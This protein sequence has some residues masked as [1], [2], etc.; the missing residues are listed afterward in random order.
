[1]KVLTMRAPSES[2]AASGVVTDAL[3]GGSGSAAMFVPPA[4][5]KRF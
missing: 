4:D 5:A 2:G 1:M 3:K